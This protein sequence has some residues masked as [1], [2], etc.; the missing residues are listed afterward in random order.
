RVVGIARGDVGAPT[1]FTT[2]DFLDG[3]LNAGGAVEELQVTTERHDVV[4]QATTARK[5]TDAFAAR[6]IRVIETDTQNQTKTLI[7]DSLSILVVFLGILAAL[8]ACVGGIGLSGTMSI[9]VLEST[10]EIGVMRAVGASNKSIYQI[11]ITEGVIVGVAS[12]AIG[13]AL[14]FPLS[15]WLTGALA[16]AV[17]F[18]LSFTFSPG[19]VALWLALVVAM[20]ALA[21]LLPAARAARVSVAEAIAYE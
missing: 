19:G 1:A 10:R 9:N 18:P 12:W 15:E 17:G 16:N 7:S 20:S 21:S 5:L 4:S 8:L 13:S 14:S 2:R 6:Q 3:A 11:F